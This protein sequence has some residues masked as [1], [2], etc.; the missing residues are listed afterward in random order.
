[1]SHHYRRRFVYDPKTKEVIEVTAPSRAARRKATYP[2]KSDAAGVHVS[3]RMDAI[4]ESHAMGIPTDFTPDGRAVFES[5]NHRK[6]YCEAIG[7]WDKD[8]GY[9][10]PQRR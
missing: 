2:M 6:R 4:A 9:S 7:H 3:Q 10:D 5:A 1:M 8:G